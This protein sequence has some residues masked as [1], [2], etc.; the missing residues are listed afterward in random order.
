MPTTH[1]TKTRIE[2]KSKRTDKQAHNQ[3][4]HTTRR[5]MQQIFPELSRRDSNSSRR[6]LQDTQGEKEHPC[7]SSNMAKTMGIL[8]R[9]A[10]ASSSSETMSTNSLNSCNNTSAPVLSS[11]NISTSPRRSIL[12]VTTQGESLSR[13]PR[14]HD[15][16]GCQL[17]NTSLSIQSQHFRAPCSQTRHPQRRRA[18]W[19]CTSATVSGR[20]QRRVRYSDLEIATYPVCLGD[21]PS[22]HGGFPLQLD[23]S[24]IPLQ[25]THE[26]GDYERIQA[27]RRASRPPRPLP[28]NRHHSVRVLSASQRSE[29]LART[30]P[31][32]YSP[33]DLKASVASVRKVQ[34]Q[35]Y[36]THLIGSYAME[37]VQEG[38]EMVRRA[39]W[40]V[41]FNRT[42]KQKEREWMKPYTKPGSTSAQERLS[43]LNDDDT[44][45]PESAKGPSATAA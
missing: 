6:A 38:L 40:N 24:Q 22:V 21:N 30:S 1:D 17:Q 34:L 19:A 5:R 44:T 43:S 16:C 7:V 23:Y 8:S 33:A 39:L 25:E 3:P 10:E 2:T 15:D 20:R 35:R 27:K 13:I 28:A 14:C 32:T 26:I 41:T 31:R 12:K 45:A 36:R 4:Y 37:P 42:H 11:K 9:S 18:S 29:R